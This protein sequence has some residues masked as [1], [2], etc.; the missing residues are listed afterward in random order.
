MFFLFLYEI[1]GEPAVTNKIKADRLRWAGRIMRMGSADIP[2]RIITGIPGGHR[3]RGRPR[4]RWMDGVEEGLRKIGC[5][6]LRNVGRKSLKRS[7]F[8]RGL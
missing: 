3:G 7:R 6:N 4:T 8:S 1:Y 5:C 2:K